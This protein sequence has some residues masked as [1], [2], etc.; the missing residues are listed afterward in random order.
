MTEVVVVLWITNGRF[1]KHPWRMGSA[2]GEPTRSSTDSRVQS[3]MLSSHL[4][5]GLPRLLSPYFV[6]DNNSLGILLWVETRQSLVVW[7]PPC[8]WCNTY[9]FVSWSMYEIFQMICQRHFISNG[10]S[11]GFVNTLIMQLSQQYASMAVL[12][13]QSSRIAWSQL[14][15]ECFWFSMCT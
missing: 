9:S 14:M 1:S 2:W 10:C 7:D 6:S 11:L 12:S 13:L 3:L 4:V 15:W 8:H 5:L